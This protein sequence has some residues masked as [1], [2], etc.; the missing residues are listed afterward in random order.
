MLHTW[1]LMPNFDFYVCLCVKFHKSSLWV[2]ILAARGPYWVSI[3]QK[4]RSLLG[5]YLKA[6]GS[7][8]VLVSV[9]N[10]HNFKPSQVEQ[11]RPT[12]VARFPC[13]RL[14]SFTPTLFQDPFQLCLCGQ[15]ST[16]RLLG[17]SRRQRLFSSWLVSPILI[18]IRQGS[19]M[20]LGFT[21]KV[22][23]SRKWSNG[24]EISEM[25]GIFLCIS[26]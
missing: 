4:N 16:T 26:L 1:E 8:I 11:P 23:R 19:S 24:V 2:L 17:W 9:L 13:S 18:R 5:P 15:V 12:C 7:L 6:W 22:R 20:R 3:S 14:H 21:A 10:F 25:G